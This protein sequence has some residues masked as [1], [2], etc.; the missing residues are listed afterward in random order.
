MKGMWGIIM[1]L[2][3]DNLVSGIN[4]TLKL[5]LMSK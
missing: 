1:L 4:L 2:V 3:F 5:D